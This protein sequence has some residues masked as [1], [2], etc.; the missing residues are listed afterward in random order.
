MENVITFK[1]RLR[2]FCFDHVRQTKLA[3]RQFFL[4]AR[5]DSNLCKRWYCYSRDVPA[6]GHDVH[7]SVRLYSSVRPSS[8]TL[9]LYEQT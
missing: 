4:P 9:V 5:Y 7:L 6:A 3:T 1:G 2:Y 8:H